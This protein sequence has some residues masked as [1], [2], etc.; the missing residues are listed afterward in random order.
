MYDR[1]L[2]PTDGS[3]GTNEAVTHAI[4]IAEQYGATLHTLYVVEST[5]SN[6][7]PD[8]DPLHRV[9]EPARR[10]SIASSSAPRTPA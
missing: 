8:D 7:T 4:D 9:Q 2:V 3:E 6:E 5:R 10:P 1:V